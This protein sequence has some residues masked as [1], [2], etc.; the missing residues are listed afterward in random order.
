M[1]DGYDVGAAV[2]AAQHRVSKED[3]SHIRRV[4]VPPRAHVTG[5]SFTEHEHA[6]VIL[7]LQV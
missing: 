5:H 1:V 2:F 3:P 6:Y 7:A 4:T